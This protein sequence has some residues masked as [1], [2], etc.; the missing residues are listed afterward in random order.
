MEF[1]SCSIS[2]T[3]PEAKS[4]ACKSELKPNTGHMN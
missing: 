3:D 4:K 2:T 1:M